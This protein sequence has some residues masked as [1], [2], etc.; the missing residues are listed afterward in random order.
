MQAQLTPGL[1]YKEFCGE[2][3]GWRTPGW[4]ESPA[5]DQIRCQ[6]L[7]RPQL[8]LEAS[9][10]PKRIRDGSGLDP[11][12]R[13]ALGEALDREDLPQIEALYRR[14]CHALEEFIARLQPGIAILP[15]DSD[16]LRGRLAARLLREAGFYVLVLSPP[17]YNQVQSYPLV[18]PRYA[19]QFWVMH[20]GF[21]QRLRAAGVA[22]AQIQIVGN[23]LFDSLANL[24][25][26][27]AEPEKLVFALQGLPWERHILRDLLQV[28]GELNIPPPSAATSSS[29]A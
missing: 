22:S 24:S 2:R 18:S 26:S 14:E 13:F 5:Y 19:Q 10:L 23:P 25:R 15:E 9:C 3:P 21:G 28:T 20:Q 17:F 7:P 16:Y 29:V 12:L 27:H 11:K 8:R 6:E 4:L 1:D